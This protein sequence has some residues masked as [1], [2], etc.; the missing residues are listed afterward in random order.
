[1]SK[2]YDRLKE[3]LLAEYKMVLKKFNV[4]FLSITPEG[5]QCNN[6]HNFPILYYFVPEEDQKFIVGNTNTK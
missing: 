4:K 3:A 5:L 1:M 6:Q 2:I